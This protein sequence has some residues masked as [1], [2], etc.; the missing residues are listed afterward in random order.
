MCTCVC[1]RTYVLSCIHVHVPDC[2]FLH[3]RFS[4]GFPTDLR[5]AP[6]SG[7]SA[8]YI[9][10]ESTGEVTVAYRFLHFRSTKLALAISFERRRY[11]HMSAFTNK[12]ITGSWSPLG[13][14][15]AAW[16]SWKWMARTCSCTSIRSEW[17]FTMYAILAHFANSSRI[18][19]CSLETMFP[20]VTF[21]GITS[22]LCRWS[23]SKLLYTVSLR[24]WAWASLP[25][26]RS[27]VMCGAS[28][29]SW[30]DYPN[31]SWCA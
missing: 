7:S 23:S 2:G 26:S 4:F 8:G 13:L 31:P 11:S 19:R 29:S 22:P 12:D 10:L 17:S 16:S 3:F 27:R 20:G 30:V 18:V 9:L 25:T 15:R 6:R 21:G 24:S 5:D 1:V 14:Q 28:V